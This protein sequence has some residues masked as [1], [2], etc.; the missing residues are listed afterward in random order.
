VQLA[1]RAPGRGDEP[2]LGVGIYEARNGSRC[3][4]V[5]QLRGSS[6]GVYSGGVFRPYA[7]DRQGSCRE[8][9]RA[10]HSTAPLGGAT[11]LYGRAAGR[12]RTVVVTLDGE[13]FSAPAGPGGAFLFVFDG[14]V[15]A[16]RASVTYR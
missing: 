16:N 7:P 3:A 6:L 15:A 2:A 13:R 8:A 4:L 12:T 5:G 9:G 1:V 10:F 11:A 14:K